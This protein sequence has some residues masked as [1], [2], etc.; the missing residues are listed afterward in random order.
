MI[1]EVVQLACEG[2]WQFSMSACLLHGG[3]L[4][5]VFSSAVFVEC[6]SRNGLEHFTPC[7]LEL[8]FVYK[9]II[10]NIEMIRNL[11]IG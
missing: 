8:G 3:F 10:F 4:T 9:S 2:M 6:G 7:C 5:A 1:F 11:I